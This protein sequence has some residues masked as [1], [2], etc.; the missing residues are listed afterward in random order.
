MGEKADGLSQ[1]NFLHIFF[2]YFPCLYLNPKLYWLGPVVW[3]PELYWLGPVVWFL[4][5]WPAA[6]AWLVH[7]FFYSVMQ[8]DWNSFSGDV[9]LDIFNKV[10]R[11][12]DNILDK[13]T[14]A[15]MFEFVSWYFLIFFLHYTKM[16]TN[17]TV[18]LKLNF[19]SALLLCAVYL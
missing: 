16:H 13:C 10:P 14:K 8:S 15:N 3:F 6:A 11:H 18:P 4:G 5:I 1:E 2:S 7:V 12:E 9:V 19:M 17:T